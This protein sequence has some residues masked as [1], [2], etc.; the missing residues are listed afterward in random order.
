MVDMLPCTLFAFTPLGSEWILE[1]IVE[2]Q[3][4]FADF[5]QMRGSSYVAL[6]PDPGFHQWNIQIVNWI[7]IA[8]SLMKKW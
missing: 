1:R 3:I 5:C 8:L 6:P 2:L 4:I 7:T